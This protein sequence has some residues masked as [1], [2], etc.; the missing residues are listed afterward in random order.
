MSGHNGDTGAW[1]MLALLAIIFA[2]PIAAPELF[3]LIGSIIWPLFYIFTFIKSVSWDAT[4]DLPMY[5]GSAMTF[6]LFWIAITGWAMGYMRS[7]TAGLA[8]LFFWGPFLMLPT[9]YTMVGVAVP[10]DWA[11]Y[12]DINYTQ[13]TC[14]EQLDKTTNKF[15][16]LCVFVPKDG[17]K[18]PKFSEDTTNNDVHEVFPYAEK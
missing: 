2:I 10:D 5:C 4:K 14:E 13:T 18:L 15:Y 17:K 1:K 11:K 3:L 6:P 9:F 8:M 12:K 7:P 16:N